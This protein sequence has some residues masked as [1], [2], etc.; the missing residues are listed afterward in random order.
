V[1]NSIEYEASATLLL[2]SSIADRTRPFVRDDLEIIVWEGIA[3]QAATFSDGEI[4][5][6]EAAWQLYRGGRS[7]LTRDETMPLLEIIGKLDAEGRTLL[8]DAIE[9]RAGVR[10]GSFS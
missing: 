1:A 10:S 4:A 7:G 5:L 9:L 8:V 3:E 6:V 2:A